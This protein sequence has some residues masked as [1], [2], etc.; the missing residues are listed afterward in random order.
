MATQFWAASNVV[1]LQSF[2][3]K[4]FI[5]FKCMHYYYYF[6]NVSSAASCRLDCLSSHATEPSVLL[7]LCSILLRFVRG[8]GT[9]TRLKRRGEKVWIKYLRK[10]CLRNWYAWM[11]K[12]R[13][14]T[15]DNRLNNSIMLLLSLLFLK[16]TYH[17]S[18]ARKQNLTSSQFGYSSRWAT[19]IC[20][21][22]FDALP[23]I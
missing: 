7:R 1:R 8:S 11:K 23:S 21:N 5:L 19:S 15:R 10:A 6:T 14:R 22:F 12:Q 18:K 17:G 2:G 20:L 3:L 13:R 9:R 4:C 16:K